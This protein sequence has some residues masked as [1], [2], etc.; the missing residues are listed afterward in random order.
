MAGSKEDKEV[1]H[2]EA[3]SDGKYKA[4]KEERRRDERMFG[5]GGMEEARKVRRGR[6]RK[7]QRWRMND[8]EE[9]D[10]KKERRR[11]K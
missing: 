4:R 3:M 6:G 11:S 7:H 10:R 5:N 1:S 8:E 9:K 2:N